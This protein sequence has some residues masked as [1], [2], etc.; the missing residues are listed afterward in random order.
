MKRKM[1]K[2]ISA[3][4]AVIILCSLAVPKAM[5]ASISAIP[6]SVSSSRYIRGYCV[7]V[8][9]TSKKRA[10]VYTNAALT[11]RN[12]NEYIDGMNDEIRIIGRSSKY[13]SLLVSYPTSK[14]RKKRYIPTGV[15]FSTN[16]WKKIIA[17]SKCQTYKFKNGKY[18]YGSISSGDTVWVYN[19]SGSYTRV[20]YPVSGGYKMAWVKNND[21]NGN[22]ANTTNT[23]TNALYGINVSGSYIT[24]GFDGYVNTKGRH[25]G[26]DF[27]YGVGKSV[28]SLTDGEV[29]RVTYGSTGSGGLSTIA[30]Y[31]SAANKTV[32]YLHTKPVSL[33]VG[34]KISR[35]TKIAT[36]S[37]RGVS[38]KG[39]AHTHVEVR[40]GRKTAAAKSVNDPTLN[41]SNP[42]SF[43]NG[44]GYTVK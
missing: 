14:G 17:S 33:S 35:G 34:Q 5:A 4:V 13:N 12:S 30:I 23:M 41:N 26:I 6:I 1:K 22:G 15:V 10:H 18:K 42:T 36:E 20:I 7:A 32:V 19:T 43:W 28:Y 21:L 2:S 38:S 11:K 24:C 25:E 39:G 27:R 3:L 40:N 29:T 44:Q 16:T 8:H 37:W 31:N 9:D